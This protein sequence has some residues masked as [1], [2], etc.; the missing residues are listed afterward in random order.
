MKALCIYDR[1]RKM[2]RAELP[3]SGLVRNL[4][5]VLCAAQRLQPGPRALCMNP[6]RDTSGQPCALNL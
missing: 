2:P 4:V 1:A 5:R 3:R 6:V